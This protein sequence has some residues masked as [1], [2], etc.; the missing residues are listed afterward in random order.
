MI[1]AGQKVKETDIATI[2]AN[3]T[4]VSSAEVAANPDAYVD[5]WL[6]VEGEIIAGAAFG[7]QTF[8]AGDFSTEETT[9]YTLEGG[10]EVMDA[11]GAPPV[12]SSGDTI[13][14]YGMVVIVDMSKMPIIGDFMEEAMEDEG[15]PGGKFILFMAKEVELASEATDSAGGDA[16]DGSESDES[17]D[18]SEDDDSAWAD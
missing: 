12:G 11:S 9:N 16:G 5:Q 4:P 17:S 18:S 2:I 3:A 6:A 1:E 14:A 13:R 8:S 10:L 7:G 15:V